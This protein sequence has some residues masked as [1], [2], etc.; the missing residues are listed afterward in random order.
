MSALISLGVVGLVRFPNLD[1]TLVS[2]YLENHPFPSDLPVLLEKMLFRED[3]MI[4]KFSQGL[5]LC[6][7]FDS[8]FC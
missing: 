6:F 4:F 1:L 5:L 3:L 8:C 7:P 2:I